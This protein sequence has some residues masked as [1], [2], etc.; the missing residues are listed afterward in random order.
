[1]SDDNV[2]DIWREAERCNINTLYK[3]AINHLVKQR[4]LGKT[5]K[6]V[7]GFSEAIQSQEKSFRDLLQ[8]MSENEA[9]SQELLQDSQIGAL[10]KELS[11]LKQELQF[12]KDINALKQELSEM[13]EMVMHLK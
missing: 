5:L 2:M 8:A 11:G 6:D 3:R 7:P 12:Q 10:K 1:M 4:P 9:H 13:K